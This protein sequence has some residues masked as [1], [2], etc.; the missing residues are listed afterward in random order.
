MQN[1]DVLEELKLLYKDHLGDPRAAPLEGSQKPMFSVGTL[2]LGTPELISTIRSL[3]A[4]YMDF[5]PRNFH[6]TSVTLS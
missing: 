4:W 6:S 3:S 5:R 2:C 1:F